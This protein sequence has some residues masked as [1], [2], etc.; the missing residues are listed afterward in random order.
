[1]KR[2]Y[3]ELRALSPSKPIALLEMGAAG[4]E[5][6]DWMREAYAAINSGKYP[7]LKAVSWWNKLRKPDGTP[8]GLEIDSTPE[9]LSAYRD[10]V[11]DFTGKP[12][13]SGL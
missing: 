4:P 3:P 13:W 10:G 6:A 1:M 9:S 12:V 2:V 5:K 8:S 7:K 11:R